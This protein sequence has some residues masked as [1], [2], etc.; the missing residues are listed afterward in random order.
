MKV[1]VSIVFKES[2]KVRI[3]EDGQ[4]VSLYEGSRFLKA[5]STFVV[6][7]RCINNWIVAFSCS[8]I[9]FSKWG[10]GK[11]SKTWYLDK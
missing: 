8:G 4:L 6:V 10:W 1:S 7:E 11:K 2:T 9:A 5:K 3:I